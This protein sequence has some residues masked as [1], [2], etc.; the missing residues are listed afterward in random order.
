[1]V[2]GKQ[3]NKALRATASRNTQALMAVCFE[4][5]PSLQTSL[6]L[7]AVRCRVGR[8]LYSCPAILSANGSGQKKESVRPT[9]KPE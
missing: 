9:F 6:E 5:A 2:G 4:G 7:S 8:W 1:M 3:P